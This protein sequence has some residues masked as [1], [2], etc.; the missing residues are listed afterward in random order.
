[1]SSEQS[2]RARFVV[3]ISG[4]AKK[5]W[6][7]LEARKQNASKLE[8]HD[9]IWHSFLEGMATMGNANGYTGLIEN[10]ENYAQVT[11][12][13]LVPLSPDERTERLSNVLARAKVRWA[14]SKAAYLAANVERI[15][16]LGGL[17]AARDL[18][19]NAQ[20]RE[21]K[22]KYLATFSGIGP[23]YA[24]S[25]LMDTYHEDFRDSLALD[26]RIHKITA[27]LGMS[28]SNYQ[29]HEDFYVDAAHEAGING[30]EMD[31]LLYYY[32]DEVL[33]GLR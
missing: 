23:K 7:D 22:I 2:S 10:P 9:F 29:S 28:F 3:V 11:F 4:M 21:G 27:A 17:E 1:M 5:Y 20:G 12:E 33:E 24:R 25:V 14:R 26:T 31:R 8:R 32:T 6:D 30:W 16:E 13:Q 18:L 19:L 15:L